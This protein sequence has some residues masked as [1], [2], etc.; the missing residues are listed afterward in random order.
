MKTRVYGVIP[1]RERIMELFEYDPETGIFT[2]IKRV[3]GMRAV[4]GTN[5]GK[6]RW[7]ICV[8]YCYYDASHLA[9]L[10]MT[11]EWPK[12]LIDH[13]DRNPLNN[14]WKNLREATKAENSRNIGI[15][16]NNKSGAR[17]VY[18]LTKRNRWCAKIV[19]DKKDITLGW[20]KLKE[21]AIEAR[22]AASIK[23]HGEF[24]GQL[25]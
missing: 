7:F 11:G 2:R 3:R 9:W 25:T 13:I 16:K 24:S 23:Y 18:W 17:G 20:F 21:D 5:S 6:N 1:T 8:D 14:S 10:V 12:K 22:K 19:V 4:A 15:N